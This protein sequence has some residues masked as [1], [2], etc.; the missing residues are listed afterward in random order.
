MTSHFQVFSWW[1]EELLPYVGRGLP[2]SH[3]TPPSVILEGL[4]PSNSP[5]NTVRQLDYLAQKVA[6]IKGI[7]PLH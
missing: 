4:R 2:P 1:G 3:H 7:L 6:S 5:F